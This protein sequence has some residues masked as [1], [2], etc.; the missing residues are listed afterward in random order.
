VSEPSGRRAR[1]GCTDLLR[2]G[3]GGS[4]GRL[5]E[6]LLIFGGVSHGCACSEGKRGNSLCQRKQ[7]RSSQSLSVTQLHAWPVHSPLTR[8]RIA[9]EGQCRTTRQR[10]DSG[11]NGQAHESKGQ[12]SPPAQSS[13][14]SAG[15]CLERSQQ[16]AAS[17]GASAAHS[18]TPRALTCSLTLQK[19]K[20]DGA[21][22]KKTQK[23]S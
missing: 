6:G 12:F 5:L 20:K 21:Q 1:E 3:V 2:V 14:S 8:T 9:S 10:H 4:R 15:W 7:G 16:A 17:P 13:P 22:K 19:K 18:T 23:N 11:K